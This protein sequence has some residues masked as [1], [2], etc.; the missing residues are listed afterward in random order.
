M[1]KYI[2][3]PCSLF[4]QWAERGGFY[5]IQRAILDVVYLKSNNITLSPEDLMKRWGWKKYGVRQQK[6][7][8]LVEVIWSEIQE[9]PIMDS[10]GIVEGSKLSMYLNDFSKSAES[11]KDVTGR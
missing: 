1:G 2:P 3:V 11:I 6:L 10:G 4:D 5:D 8:D 9:L 7:I